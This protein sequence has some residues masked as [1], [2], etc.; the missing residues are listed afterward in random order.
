M[1]HH[2]A[3]FFAMLG[4]LL[5]FVVAVIALA[6]GVLDHSVFWFSAGLLSS[7]LLIATTS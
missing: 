3:T 7:A 5:V 4:R 1:V 2:L 6:C